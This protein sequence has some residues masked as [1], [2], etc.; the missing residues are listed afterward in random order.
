MA[1]RRR[2]LSNSTVQTV[3]ETTLR[4]KRESS[5]LK[6]VPA[7]KPEHDWPTFVLN[8]AV[9]YRM[10]GTT[11]G[12]PLL[13]DT[14]GPFVIRGQLEIDDKDQEPLLVRANTRAAYVEIA[15]S[16]RY[17]IGY[18][19]V[20]FWVSGAAGWYE[21]RPAPKY[22][23]VYAEILEAITLYYE[24]MGASESYDGLVDAA[25]SKRKG[26]KG[27]PPP[28]LTIDDI[29]LQYA[30]AVGDG[31]FYDEVVLRCD[32]WAQFFIS[33][34]HKET[35][36][37]W[38]GNTFYQWMLERHPD[39][40]QTLADAAARAASQPRRVSTPREIEGSEAEQ[41]RS[42]ATRGRPS[43][44]LDDVS[45]ADAPLRQRGRRASNI[46]EH[47]RR[48]ASMPPRQI[49]DGTTPVLFAFIDVLDDI[50]ADCRDANK[51]DER[52]IRHKMYFKCKVSYERPI[53]MA[54][55]F[56][57]G[58]LEHLGP[59]WASTP[60]YRWLKVVS[61]QKP[62]DLDQNT[63]DSFEH[64]VLL[65]E[66]KDRSSA[67]AASNAV[68]SRAQTEDTES[69]REVRQGKRP[70]GNRTAGKMSALRPRKRLA[71][72]ADMEEE[73]SP[74]SH[75][76][77][78]GSATRA[79]LEYGETDGSDMED[80]EEEGNTGLVTPGPN[81]SVRLVVHAEKLPTISPSGPDGAWL[82][83][84]EDCNYIVR[85]ADDD[86][87]KQLIEAHFKEH[88]MQAQRLN[89]AMEEGTRGHN[90][91]EHLIQKLQMMSGNAAK[92]EADSDG[93]PGPAPIK[94]RLLI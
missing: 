67:A 3:D 9:V 80:S 93:E 21:I 52:T 17:A 58:L 37:S 60:F 71:L 38:K 57:K 19:P 87:G 75:R 48:R 61:K 31:V 16:N 41:P 65:R 32:R 1:G 44:D 63:I 13:V 68:S 84:E 35:E 53:E 56:S 64:N 89:L 50:L 5:V 24:I 77:R 59:H 40:Q 90:P 2:R 74:T 54:K 34:F 25:R 27:K 22:R 28:P 46:K 10:D 70:L 23:V 6:P 47:S 30:Q 14:E 55:Y 18:G 11:L 82:C 91:I 79:S 88:E 86:E 8:D 36:Y 83:D 42:R 49:T 81:D 85:R 43:S 45:M 4:P 12:N 73:A 72:D 78:T 66:K 39:V 7:G 69:A 94:R 62:D 15:R 76:Q 20:S 92:R 29:F 51:V 26:K 33:H